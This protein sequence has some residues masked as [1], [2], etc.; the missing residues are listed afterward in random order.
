MKM[1]PLSGTGENQAAT[2]TS[3]NSKAPACAAREC[4]A[5]GTLA[6]RALARRLARLEVDALALEDDRPAPHLVEDRQHVLADH[7]QEQQLDPAEEEHRE[8]DGRDAGLRPHEAER[9]RE[10]YTDRIKEAH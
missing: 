7:A 2:S 3:S 9:H 1:R 4:I 8:D 10:E 6:R 5:T